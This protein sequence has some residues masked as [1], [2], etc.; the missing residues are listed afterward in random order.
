MQHDK[1]AEQEQES[2]GLSPLSL[3][4]FGSWEFVR[5]TVFSTDLLLSQMGCLML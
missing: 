1:C 3:N 2:L 4:L 5:W